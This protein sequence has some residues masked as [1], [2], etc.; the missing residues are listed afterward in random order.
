MI[1]PTR[2][3]LVP[4]PTKDAI[5]NGMNA[6]PVIP[7]AT[8][9]ILYG[10]GENPETKTIKIPHWSIESKITSRLF[11]S[12]IQLKLFKKTS[13]KKAPIKYPTIPPNTEK[14]VAKK[15]K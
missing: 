4:L 7:D 11:S 1:K 3:N 2:K 10:I 9:K 13:E 15:E 14:I 12:N 6:K 8:V 5:K